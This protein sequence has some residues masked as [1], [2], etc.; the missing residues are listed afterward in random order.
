VINLSVDEIEKDGRN[1]VISPNLLTLAVGDVD[2]TRLERFA[3]RATFS[4]WC[5]GV[6]PAASNVRL[7][8]AGFFTPAG[9][10]AGALGVSEIF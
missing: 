4:E 6:V 7:A 3:I 2:G 8:E 5:G 9:V 10:F 1:F